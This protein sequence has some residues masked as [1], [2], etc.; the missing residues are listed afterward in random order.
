MLNSTPVLKDLTLGGFTSQR[1]DLEMVPHDALERL[2]V[3]GGYLG[4]PPLATPT[5]RSLELTWHGLK[6]FEEMW[7]DPLQD[8]STVL[9]DRLEHLCCCYCDNSGGQQTPPNFQSIQPSC[10]NGT[11]RSL[12]ITFDPYISEALDLVLNKPYIHTL[13]C[14]SIGLG[15][16]SN[17]YDLNEHV[18]L[19]LDWVDTFRGLNTIGVYPVKTEKAW[20]VIA[21]LMK[22]RPDI[23]T[24]FTD[25]L[26]GVYRDE[27]LKR[28]AENG[29][30]IIE[31]NRVP[32]PI[33]EAVA[34]NPGPVFL[35]ELE[36]RVPPEDRQQEYQ[37]YSHD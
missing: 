18:E 16:F 33:L 20:M 13:S 12:H 4:P 28:A 27:I 7:S 31:E 14:H 24:I 36:P 25:V 8:M 5:L 22:R 34:P 21:R 30:T 35:P 2:C 15:T 37:E 11:L 32:E 23:K 9:L 17:H 26:R 19:Y 10:D 6:T 3:S 1:N 29:I